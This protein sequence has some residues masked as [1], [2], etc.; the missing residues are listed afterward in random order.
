MQLRVK[1]DAGEPLT[2]SGLVPGQAVV[3]VEFGRC[4]QISIVA[5]GSDP[6]PLE[7][8]PPLPNDI[9]AC[10]LALAK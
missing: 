5:A 6:P 8:T 4:Q 7:P 9:I 2:I 1:T 10:R 3:I